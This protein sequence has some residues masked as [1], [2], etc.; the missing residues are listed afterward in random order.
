[1]ILFEI[2]YNVNYTNF[3]AMQMHYFRVQIPAVGNT[4]LFWI[5]VDN[6]KN[7]CKHNHEEWTGAI[8]KYMQRNIPNTSDG[9]Q[10]IIRNLFLFTY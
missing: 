2:F 9:R 10:I 4:V 6:E 5:F 3:L 1:M 8:F 7:G